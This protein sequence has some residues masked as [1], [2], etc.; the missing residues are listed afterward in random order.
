[1]KGKVI[2]RWSIGI[3]LMAALGSAGH[4]MASDSMP[5]IA[6]GATR[7]ELIEAYGAPTGR[8]AYGNIEVLYFKNAQAKL[9]NGKLERLSLKPVSQPAIVLESSAAPAAAPV[10]APTKE[11][12]SPLASAWLTDIETALRDAARRNSVVLALFTAS[13]A[14]PTSRQF[15]KEIVLHPE[16]V[17]AFRTRYVLLQVDFPVQAERM[18]ADANEQ[19]ETLRDRYG[20]RDMPALLILSG[21]GEKIAEVEISKAV[22]GNAFR[23]RLIGAV[24][25]AYELPQPA[26]PVPMPPPI[27]PPLPAPTPVVVAPM[28]V[29][30]ALETARYLITGAMVVGTL[31]AGVMLFAVWLLLRKVNKPVS[32]TRNT[33]MAAR[34][35]QAASGLPSFDEIRVW[36]KE[37]LCNVITRLAETEGYLA[38]PQPFGSD[39]DLVL[40]RPGNPAPQI[41]VRCV[42]GNAGV[43]PV[44]R[45][46]EMAGMLAAEDVPA[47]WF[48]A[49]M[50]FAVETRAFAEQNNIRLMDGAGM[51][52]RLSD[53]P[54]F[55]LPKVLGAAG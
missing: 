46:R 38:E 47:G 12:I 8:S 9:S 28:E 25:G 27:V 33:S 29:T 26:E 11:V 30:S 7:A 21:T 16:F 31:I 45:V 24:S 10:I 22:P 40:K 1:M 49:P 43:I 20:V 14:T 51:L 19:N 36:P 35:D 3:R 41:V 50:G 37:T 42:T 39:K 55:A 48:I 34:I 13:D 4:L 5:A 23:G 18:M 54:M 52:N 15:Q 17:N 53:L 6:P 32:V 2:L 44:R